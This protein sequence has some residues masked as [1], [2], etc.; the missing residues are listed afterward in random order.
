[1][2]DT[3]DKRDRLPSFAVA[4]TILD[5]LLGPHRHSTS[6]EEILEE[7]AGNDVNRDPQTIR[8]RYVQAL[9]AL[10]WQL[11]K[12][13]RPGGLTVSQAQKHALR[14][15]TFT[16]DELQALYF[17]L[18][19]AT[20]MLHGGQW[21]QH[22]K[23][24]IRK[25]SLFLGAELY[26]PQTFSASFLAFQKQFKA[27]GHPD[28]QH[29]LLTLM[30]ATREAIVCRVAYK[31]PQA[32]HASISTIHPYTLAV[33]DNGLYLFAYRPDLEA[34]TVLA[35]ER[36]QSLE[37]VQSEPATPLQTAALA[38]FSRQ[39]W[40]CQ[41]IEARRRRAFGL[42]DDG[43]EL[44]V[45]LRIAPDQAPYVAE[46]HWHATQEFEPQADGSLVM[47]F[48][49]SGRFEI[50]R[51]VL[52]WGPAVEVL[53]PEEIRQHIALLAQKATALYPS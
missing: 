51:W 30:A 18:S 15:L 40:V 9:K 50:V 7:L 44:N 39:P 25:V 3:V 2:V 5:L 45:V 36:L 6:V 26:N 19:L 35:V 23:T 11:E 14:L 10:G 43:A 52:G 12:P 27:Y 47:R 20:P 33:Y 31:T 38:H 1:M 13:D 8:R 28:I 37:F 24:V 4:M 22:L 17:H 21:Q 32:R 16:P 29:T 42:I 53:A 34:V 49:A 48:Q 41:E 46:R